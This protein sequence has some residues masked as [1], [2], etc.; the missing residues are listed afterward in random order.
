M[1]K[2]IYLKLYEILLDD[3]KSK[4]LSIKLPSENELASKY[5]VNRH[6]IRKSLQKL[7]DDGLIHTKLGQGNFITNVHVEYNIGKNSS[8]SQTLRDLGYQ[9]DTKIISVNR[10]KADEKKANFFGITTKMDL[11]EFKLLRFADGLPIYVTYSYFDAF[12]FSKLY[13][14]YDFKPFSLYELIKKE[15]P[16][17]KITKISSFFEAIKPNDEIKKH[18]YLP[19]HVPVLKTLTISKDQYLNPV[20]YGFGYLRGDTCKVK[21]NLI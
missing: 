3:I 10:V 14:N 16:R 19:L 13:E 5:G 12:R 2:P 21:M 17:L 7:K 15:Y 18:L 9:P 6:T 8:F 20:E 11:I 4:K 1:K